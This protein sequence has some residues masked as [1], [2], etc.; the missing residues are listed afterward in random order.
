MPCCFARSSKQSD[1]LVMVG[2]N[3]PSWDA[4]EM[5]S[6]PRISTIGG[7]RTKSLKIW[8]L[9]GQGFNLGAALSRSGFRV[10]AFPRV[11]FQYC[12]STR[13]GRAFQADEKAHSNRLIIAADMARK[14]RPDRKCR[15]DDQPMKRRIPSVGVMPADFVFPDR[16]SE[17][18]VPLTLPRTTRTIAG[19]SHLRVVAR[20]KPRA[21]QQRRNRNGLDH[22]QLEQQ[23]DQHGHEP[24]CLALRQKLWPVSA[25]AARAARSVPS[26]L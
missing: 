11:S 7:L 3:A 18:W 9:F 15:Q 1:Q 23:T 4:N 14:L 13:M 25:R 6:R 22:A 26:F 20:L 21:L 17:I 8:R 5:L 2:R 16:S 24:R 12:A 19:R 10:P